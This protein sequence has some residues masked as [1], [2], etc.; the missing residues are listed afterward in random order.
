ML[1]PSG[2]VHPWY[3]AARHRLQRLIIL[4]GHKQECKAYCR[5]QSEMMSGAGLSSK[6]EIPGIMAGVARLGQAMRCVYQGGSRGDRRVSMTNDV[7]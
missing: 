6:E 4:Q 5:S 1:A 2:T 3:F 7:L